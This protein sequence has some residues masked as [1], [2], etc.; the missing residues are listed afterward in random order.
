MG[1]RKIESKLWNDEI[2]HVKNSSGW[3]FN[4]VSDDRYQS[5]F[6]IEM[7]DIEMIVFKCQ[8]PK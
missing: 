2:S 4:D 6:V 7:L 5:W 8:V 3:T 1:E